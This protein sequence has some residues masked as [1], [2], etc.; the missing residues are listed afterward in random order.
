MLQ[1][2][3]SEV[4]NAKVLPTC[5]NVVSILA[6]TKDA[7]DFVQNLGLDKFGLLSQC[8]DPHMKWLYV[9]N[10]YRPTEIKD[11]ILVEWDRH[12]KANALDAEKARRK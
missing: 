12:N 5:L 4:L 3:P 1:I 10:A 8:E 9:S 6:S 2:Q 7:K 11:A